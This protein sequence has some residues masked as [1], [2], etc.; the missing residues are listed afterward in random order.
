MWASASPLVHAGKETRPGL[1]AVTKKALGHLVHPAIGRVA[2]LAPGGTH[3][4]QPHPER[5]PV[6]SSGHTRLGG[7]SL[8]VSDLGLWL[9]P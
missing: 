2:R 5:K 7:L 6:S 1:A 8:S 9:G 3:G 4:A